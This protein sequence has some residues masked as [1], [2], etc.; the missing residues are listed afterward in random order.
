M[1]SLILEVPNP[2]QMLLQE[3][4]ADESP[5]VD[6]GSTSVRAPLFVAFTAAL[7]ARCPG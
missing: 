2:E 7:Q 1:A 3:G 5:T 4:V 6:R